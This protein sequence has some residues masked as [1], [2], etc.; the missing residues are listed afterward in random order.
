MRAAGGIVPLSDNIF[1]GQV[2]LYKGAS[3]FWVT[4]D[5][6]TQYGPYG[7]VL[8]RALR[9]GP[10]Y[11]GHEENAATGLVHMQQRYYDPESRARRTRVEN[12]LAFKRCRHPDLPNANATAS[13]S[14]CSRNTYS[15]G[16]R[17]QTP[18]GYMRKLQAAFPLC[19]ALLLGI[20]HSADG[21]GISTC[22][23]HCDFIAILTQQIVAGRDENMRVDIAEDLAEYLK[24]YPQCGK[25]S[26]TVRDIAHLLSDRNDG[27]V[28][29]AAEALANIGPPAKSATPAL[30]K[31]LKISD[32][33]AKT[34]ASVLL[35]TSSV[36]DVIRD[37]LERINQPKAGGS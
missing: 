24:D 30:E 12:P 2:S 16:E 6:R 32:A 26:A 20:A 5:D 15:W 4:D 22:N 10:G 18:W 27:V 9:D 21:A 28:A 35:P 36:S 34:T 13:C 19:L 8:N 7:A 33:K 31:A 37:A 29:G 3:T 1:G 11:A 17:R 23:A 25:D 14:Y